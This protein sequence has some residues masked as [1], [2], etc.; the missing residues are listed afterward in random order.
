MLPN[1]RVYEQRLLHLMFMTVAARWTNPH[2][3]GAVLSRR[4]ATRQKS[5]NLQKKFST[6]PAARRADGFAEAG[7]SATET[8]NG[9]S[10]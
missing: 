2:V 5:F 9:V 4:S 10:Q 8:A 3:A 6:A 7:V 1:P